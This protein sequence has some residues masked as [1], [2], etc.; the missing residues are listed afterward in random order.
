MQNWS[1]LEYVYLLLGQ[2]CI[3]TK[4]YQWLERPPS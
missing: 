3:Q 1:K 4:Y 2:Y